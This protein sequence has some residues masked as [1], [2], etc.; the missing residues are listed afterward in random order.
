MSVAD[1]RKLERVAVTGG[2][3]YVGSHLCALLARR[4]VRVT[5]ID[6]LSLGSPENI[7]EDARGDVDVEPIDILDGARLSAALTAQRPDAVFHLAAV[8]FI[9]ACEAD[10]QRAIRINVQG[11]ESVLHACCALDA[12]PAV[13]LASTAAV[14]A[15]SS[16]SHT[17]EDAVGPTDIY[18]LTK[19]WAEQLG[20]LHH[21]RRGL[22]VA[23]ARLFNVFGPGETNPHLIPTVI[24]QLRQRPRL[25]LGDL[26]TRRDYVFVDDVADG[27]LKLAGAA[28]EREPPI[29]NLGRGAAVSGHDVVAAIA[30]LMNRDVQLE[31]DT[32]RFRVSDRPFL[33]SDSRRAQRLIGWT[34]RTDLETGLARTLERPL[35]AGVQIA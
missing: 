11:T 27:L 26:T 33:N 17:E 34:A 16:E 20:A 15:P 10:P 24:H 12:L 31:T 8:H 7:P 13:V 18:G 23:V 9:P 1:G 2:C 32:R 30:R 3:G 19:W 5:A 29:V 6:D 35:A 14:Y 4:G 22:P 28:G 21:S 25:A